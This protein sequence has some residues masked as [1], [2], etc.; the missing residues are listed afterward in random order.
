V[1]YGLVDGRPAFMWDEGSQ[2]VTV[3]VDRASTHFFFNILARCF[4]T[5]LEQSIVVAIII[6]GVTVLRS[7][8]YSVPDSLLPFAGAPP[9]RVWQCADGQ[10][11]TY[12]ECAALTP[13]PGT[14]PLE[15][16]R[17]MQLLE[18]AKLTGLSVDTLKRS[19]HGK[20]LQLTPR[21]LGMRVADVLQIS[22][23]EIPPSD[24]QRTI[25]LPEVAKFTGVSVDS[26]KRYHHD[27]IKPLSAHLLGMQIADMLRIG[28]V[29]AAA[30]AAPQPLKRRRRV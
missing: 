25:R 29:E 6:Q 15:Q 13:P 14:P 4:P 9:N 17:I 22:L 12:A 10:Y 1:F 3:Y 30:P 26:L 18:A 19:R 21:R 5:P 2:M 27:K 7:S 20:V 11:R 8:N 24:L 16:W 28:D 23:P